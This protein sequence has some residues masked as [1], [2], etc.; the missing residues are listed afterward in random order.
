MFTLIN[1]GACAANVAAYAALGQ[2]WYN[3]AA[4]VFC[5]LL[6][7]ASAIQDAAS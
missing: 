2:A 1:A 3:L 5:G 4:A 7:V 6:A